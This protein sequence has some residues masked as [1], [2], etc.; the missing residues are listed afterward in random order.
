VLEKINNFATASL[1]PSFAFVFDL[2]VEAAAERLRKT[3]KAVDRLEG[4]GREFYERVRKG[5]LALAK[6]FPHRIMVL[7]GQGPVE[8]LSGRVCEKILELY[9]QL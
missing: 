8:E 5:Y 9:G 6:R 2:P 4:S 7:P 3:G 1:R